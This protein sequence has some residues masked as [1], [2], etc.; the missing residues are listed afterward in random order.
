MTMPVSTDY[1]NKQID[2]N[3]ENIK[4]YMP[5][6]SARYWIIKDLEFSKYLYSEYVKTLPESRWDC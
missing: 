2:E 1:Y 3:I 6:D 4:K 5:D